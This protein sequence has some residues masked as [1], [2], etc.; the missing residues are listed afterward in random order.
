MRKLFSF[1]IIFA[2]FSFVQGQLLGPILMSQASG[3]AAAPTFIQQCVSQ[4]GASTTF[5]CSAWSVGNVTAG[6][7][8]VGGAGWFSA[9]DTLTSVAATC[10][11]GNLTLVDN[12]TVNSSAG[13]STAGFYGKVNA[14]GSCTITGTITGADYGSIIEAHEIH[15]A[16]ASTPL[17]GHSANALGYGVTPLTSNAATTTVNNDYIFGYG[18]N[19]CPT[20]FA[21]GSGFTLR[22]TGSGVYNGAATEDEAQATAGS[23]AA[24]FTGGCASYNNV[25]MM[26]F[27]P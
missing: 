20:L 17:D 14:T 8:I 12:P 10:V 6:N 24:I 1:T 19:G 25:G 2:L 4:G 13:Y 26:A 22:I 7:W 5:T 16:A 15:G 11:T 27:H 3:G 21:A 9:T 23:V 18:L